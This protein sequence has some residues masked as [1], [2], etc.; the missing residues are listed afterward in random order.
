M[1]EPTTGGHFRHAVRR[2]QRRMIEEYE[3]E[4]AERARQQRGDASD[5]RQISA[6]RGM[7]RESGMHLDRLS[8]I[9]IDDVCSWSTRLLFK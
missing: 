1:T 2:E 8:P 3:Q 4:L 7:L 6:L 9:E 5:G